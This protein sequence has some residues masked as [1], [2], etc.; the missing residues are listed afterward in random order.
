MRIWLSTIGEPVPVDACSRDRLLRTGYFA[1]FL[2]E[3]GHDV[4]W[5][6]ST[7]DHFRKQHLFPADNTVQI[8]SHLEIRLLHGCGYQ[9]NLSISRILDHR[10][11]A[12]KFSK[13]AKTEPPPDIIVSAFPAIELSLEAIKYGETYQVPVIIDIRDMWPDIFVDSVPNPLMAFVKL[14]TILMF[15]QSQRIFSSATGITGITNAFVEWSIK[16]GDRARSRFDKAFP[17][18]YINKSPSPD[19]LREAEQFWDNHGVVETNQR[20]IVCYV[21]T[22]AR[23]ADLTTV[24]E[25]ARKLRQGGKN[26]LFVICGT[27]D[28]F[29]YYRSMITDD[30]NIIFTGWV[31]FSQIYILMR[32]S[33]VGLDPLP[34]R[35]DFL[36]TVNNKA[37]EY[38]SAGLP[39][40]SSPD[41]GTLCNLLREK[42]CGV[43][44]T[45]GDVNALA[46]ALGWLCDNSAALKR[47]SENSARLF[48]EM[49]TAEKVYSE[50]MDYLFE[51]AEKY[52][53][54]RRFGAQA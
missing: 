48:Q 1:H 53:Q 34:D 16:R 19:K 3:N 43:S 50:M 11:I 6:T 7:F 44:Y 41:R 54:R 15:K 24:I 18:G 39:I 23:W 27:G 8:N 14:L 5:W 51:V 31:D 37:I 9:S 10:Q 40:I 13:M 12:R 17:L 28:R 36:A 38:M 32:R 42:D 45:Y 26:I 46:N 30:P 33:A 29:E 2:A 25:A 21:G 35:Y 52:K 4:V 22:I 47:M 20:F 49:F